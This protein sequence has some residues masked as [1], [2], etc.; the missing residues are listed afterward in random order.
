M[1]STPCTAAPARGRRARPLAAFIL[2]LLSVPFS[3]LPSQQAGAIEGRVTGANT[4]LPLAGVVVRL[5]GTPRGTVTG[6]DG[7]YRIDG[8]PAGTAVVVAHRAG[9][10]TA[11]RP[12]TIAPGQTL[13]ADFALAD[14]AL[15]IAPT[16]VSAAREITRRADASI[17]IDVLDGGEVRRSR[18]AHPAELL[19]RLPGVHVSQLSGEGHS[20]AIR[21]PITT[22][23]MYL[24]LEDGI[25]TRPT[26][27]FNHNALYEVNIPQSNGIEVLKGPGTALYGSD[28]IGGVV[29]VLTRPAPVHPSVE[30]SV[31]GGA[32]G[33]GRLLAT[34]GTT[35][36]RHGVRADVNL[37]RADGWRDQARYERQ[38]GTV[39]WDYASPGG[40]TV[41]TVLTGSL[42]DQQDVPSI[43]QALF[44]TLPEFNRAPIAF[45][46]VQ[47]LRLSS[48]IETERGATLWSVTPFARYNVLELLPSWQLTFDPQL[49]DTRSRSIGLLAKVRHDLQPLHARVIAG[50]DLDL[51]PG[52]F[53]ARQAVTTPQQGVW[54]SYTLG[55]THYD[56]DVT[57]RAASPY[58]QAEL[59]PLPKL[60]LD[61]GLRWDAVGYV[62]R[63]RLTPLQTGAHRRP[64]DT[65]LT[66]SRVSPKIGVVY[67]AR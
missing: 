2:L 34:G 30:A 57:Y 18:A 50:V 43:G 7:R 23:P 63:S 16:V 24:Y 55:D 28:A 22:K 12:L 3:I 17:T 42:I 52:S 6:A 48:A 47:A 61:V 58:V 46:K 44:D 4:A 53:L 51:S 41:R 65:T 40:L 45:R 56:Y 31:E 62:Y 27:F 25:P 33:H 37:T 49:W 5:D 14:Q 35:A 59:T 66:Y 10:V 19:N 64:A 1:H 8:V 9:L 15:L 60:R 39:R 54:S 32:Y 21:Q 29:N 11:R 36:G 26:G 13:T 67:E 20:M 38:S